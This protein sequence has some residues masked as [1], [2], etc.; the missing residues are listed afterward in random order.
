MFEITATGPNRLDIRYSGK[1][2]KDAMK[3]ALD[4]LIQQSEGIEHG[5]M[6]FTVG[7]YALPSL[8]AIVLEMT[9]IPHL[10]KFIKQFDRAAVL[11]NQ[12]WLQKVSELEGLLLPGLKIR[13]FNL[14]QEAEAEAWLS[15]QS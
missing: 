14:D 6:L 3:T 2:D 7:D 5:T 10:F 8:D 13:A 9:Y 15:G 1:L 11:A 12:G 4:D